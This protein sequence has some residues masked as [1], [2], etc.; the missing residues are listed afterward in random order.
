MKGGLRN[1]CDISTKQRRVS[2]DGA[3]ITRVLTIPHLRN[4]WQMLFWKYLGF[5]ICACPIGRN[6][7]QI[8]RK[9]CNLNGFVLWINA[10]RKLQSHK[11]TLSGIFLTSIIKMVD[12]VWEQ[13]NVSLFLLRMKIPFWNCTDTVRRG[14]RLPWSGIACSGSL[15]PL[16]LQCMGAA[17]LLLFF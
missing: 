15:L 11:Q 13:R 3:Y 6:H 7:F 14:L 1:S 4:Y 16:G 8:F 9:I 17:L 10:Q 5:R 2:R 12:K